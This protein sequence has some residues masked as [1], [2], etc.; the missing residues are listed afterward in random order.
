V[1]GLDVVSGWLVRGYAHVFIPIS[2]VIVTL[3]AASADS[4]LVHL[5]EQ[6]LGRS[7]VNRRNVMTDISV[8]FAVRPTTASCARRAHDIPLF[9]CDLI[10][11]VF[12]SVLVSVFNDEYFQCQIQFGSGS[13]SDLKTYLTPILYTV[14]DKHAQ[15]TSFL[16][17]LLH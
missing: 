3:R 1:G 9:R 14:S 5:T 13:R 4:Q 10:C 15:D 7:D 2:V 8:F 17:F 6:G 16:T 12:R 11:N